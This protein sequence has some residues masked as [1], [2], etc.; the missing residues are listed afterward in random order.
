MF[1]C[2]CMMMHCDNTM[3]K[4]SREAQRGA[5]ALLGLIAL[6][7][8]F[9]A[10]LSNAARVLEQTVPERLSSQT[11][12]ISDN[13]VAAVRIFEEIGRMAGVAIV[14]DAAITNVVS[15]ERQQSSLYSLFLELLQMVDGLYFVKDGAI[16]VVPRGAGKKKIPGR[17]SL[18]LRP[19]HRT[20]EDLL[21]PLQ[22]FFARKDDTVTWNE[23]ENCLLVHDTPRNVL[24]IRN[25]FLQMDRP[26]AEYCVTA[27]LFRAD[28]GQLAEL[29]VV[30][31]IASGDGE[32]DDSADDR[33]RSA[34][35]SSQVR[36]VG[37]L[38]M[39]DEARNVLDKIT[40]KNAQPNGVEHKIRMAGN[41]DVLFSLDS[42]LTGENM[43]LGSYLFD[44]RTRMSDIA[45]AYIEIEFA[46]QLQTGRVNGADQ[47]VIAGNVL[48]LHISEN[49]MLVIVPAM[50]ENDL[51]A[52]NE[53]LWYTAQP[54]AKAASAETEETNGVPAFV[55]LLLL[56]ARKMGPGDMC[57]S[58]AEGRRFSP[59][60]PH[61]L[62]GTRTRIVVHPLRERERYRHRL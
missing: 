33:V 59:A 27:G 14:V 62:P 28:A 61:T 21:L 58:W 13:R 7:I 57:G 23:A 40:G 6:I 9:S 1:I 10:Q 26:I 47:G 3:R 4:T 49:G 36:R 18:Q 45:D 29:P 53:N 5:V 37:E 25:A 41:T 20:C 8:L 11:M 55:P 12:S 52:G 44:V 22:A 15:V 30:W 24:K 35:Y 38:T 54:D 2:N 16:F 56:Q 46:S 43:A 32:L 51:S 60:A 19:Q 34:P 39:T 17:V 48:S 31:M 42:E 50:P